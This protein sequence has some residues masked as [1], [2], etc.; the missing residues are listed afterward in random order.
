[1]RDLATIFSAAAYV[2]WRSF[3]ESDDSRFVVL[4][5]PH[6]L[7][8]LPYAPQAAPVAEFEFDEWDSDFLAGNS[9][10]DR[11]CWMNA[12]YLLAERITHAF[13]RDGWC[14]AIRGIEGGGKVEGL[15]VHAFPVEEGSLSLKGPAEVA[16]DDRRE[17]QLCDLGF[18]PLCSIRKSTDA[19]FFSGQTAHRPRTHEDEDATENARISAPL[20]LVLAASR[21]GHYVIVIARDKLKARQYPSA[22][23]TDLNRW[24][25][26]YVSADPPPDAASKARYPLQEANVQIRAMPG[27]PGG[28]QAVLKLRFWDA[29][30]D[31]IDG[32][33]RLI[34]R[35]SPGLS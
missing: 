21:F 17:A 32:T 19:V 31:G 6:V 12:A 26:D 8:R 9:V 18:L 25:A 30:A 29:A 13:A 3:R 33:I 5:L 2:A 24:L 1:M 11:C 14:T 28:W 15:P 20:P 27:E 22:I 34:L 35:I 7:A 23:E 16:I 4:T 10:R